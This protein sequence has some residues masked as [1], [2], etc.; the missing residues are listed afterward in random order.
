M[1]KGTTICGVSVGVNR[2]LSINGKYNIELSLT[3]GSMYVFNPPTNDY[4]THSI[5]KD[6]TKGSR[7]SLTFRNY[8]NK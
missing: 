2:T 5:C 4:N 7:I 6:N 3:S 8:S 1:T